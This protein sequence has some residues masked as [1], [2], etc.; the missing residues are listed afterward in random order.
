MIIRKRMKIRR[1]LRGD[2]QDADLHMAIEMVVGEHAAERPPA[3]GP[4]AKPVRIR[5]KEANHA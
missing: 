1:A 2:E 5:P 4:A 3:Q